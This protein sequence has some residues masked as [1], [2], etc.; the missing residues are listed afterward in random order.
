MKNHYSKSSFHKLYL[1][2]KEMY[3]RILPYINEV[4]KQEINDL[5][6]EHRPEYEDPDTT[7]IEKTESRKELNVSDNDDQSEDLN[8]ITTEI[9]HEVPREALREAARESLR[10]A[11]QL[12]TTSQEYLQPVEEELPIDEEKFTSR[13][14][15]KLKKIKK[16]ACNICV[17]KKFTTRSSLNRHHKTFHM[18]QPLN[19]AVE[20][21]TKPKDLTSNEGTG[22]KHTVSKLSTSVKRRREDDEFSN[23]SDEKSARYGDLDYELENTPAKRGL[24]RKVTIDLE[25]RKKFHWESFD[26]NETNSNTDRAYEANS[27]TLNR[28]LK[29]KGPTRV[30]DLEPRKK[31]R[32]E[33]Y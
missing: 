24:K 31:F 18:V 23:Y 6:E 16:Y 17:N 19:K 9:S 10:E 33:T 22:L 28:G 2:E 32:W 7:I 15:N 4:D 25:P 5:N 27:P 1:I 14:G 29:R 13:K 21:E 11:S 30:T 26:G 12:T 20:I 3:D 8:E